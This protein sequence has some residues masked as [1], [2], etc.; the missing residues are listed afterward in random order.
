MTATID[1]AA[2][3]AMRK[4]N[5]STLSKIVQELEKT[6]TNFKEDDDRLWKATVDKAGNGSAVIRF[7]PAVGENDLPWVRVYDKGFQGPTGRWYIEKCLTTIGAADPVVE[8]C[9]KL[10]GG[11]E[12]DKLLAKKMKRRLGYYANV[13]V[14]KDPGNPANEGKVF[15]FKFGKKLFEKLKDALQPQFEDMEPN[16]FFDPYEGSNFRLRIRRVDNYSNTDKS[17]FEH[18]KSWIV[19][20]DEEKMVEILSKRH[21]LNEFV[22]PKTFKSYDELQAKFRRVMSTEQSAG[23]EKA[24]AESGAAVRA[25]A[26]RVGKTKDEPRVPVAATVAAPAPTKS[27]REAVAALG[28]EID[29]EEDDMEFFNKLIEED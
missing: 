27:Q 8:Y 12:E 29:S 25:A 3:R 24:V 19:E 14:V 15:I 17:D 18:Q 23:L 1:L 20:N 5:A 10:W 11:T 9:N 6:K 28:R 7:L 13:Y 4:N 2:L 26:G 21:D 16:V 22:D